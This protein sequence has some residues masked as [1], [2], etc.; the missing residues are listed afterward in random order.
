MSDYAFLQ[1]NIER[2]LSYADSKFELVLLAARRARQIN[3]YFNQ[4]GEG[5]G[6]I[7][8]PQVWSVSRQPLS[9]ALEEIAC[10][11]IRLGESTGDEFFSLAKAIF[12]GAPVSFY[13]DS[14]SETQL[15][16]FITGLGRIAKANNRQLQVEDLRQGSWWGWLAP[17]GDGKR[18][19]TVER[20]QIEEASRVR[21]LPGHESEDAVQYSQAVREFARMLEGVERVAAYADGVLFVKWREDGESQALVRELSAR[22]RADYEA[23]NL[24]IDL[25]DIDAVIRLVRSGGAV[26]AIK[27]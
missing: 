9:I 1:P 21:P 12:D 3:S 22:E 18:L 5:L 15:N 14:S 6:A 16:K 19:S 2:L 11:K 27:A 7:V 10:G 23:G 25:R 17:Y 4:L 13:I 20:A 8:P 24:F 26:Q